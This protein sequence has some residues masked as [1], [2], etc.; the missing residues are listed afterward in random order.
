MFVLIAFYTSLL[1]V[2]NSRS[3]SSSWPVILS[4]SNSSSKSEAVDMMPTTHTS[5]F[6]RATGTSDSVRLK[7][8]EML[9]SALQTGG[10][11]CCTHTHTRARTLSAFERRKLH[12]P[13]EDSRVE[14]TW[15]KS[16]GN[17]AHV[18]WIPF[19][20]RGPNRINLS[21]HA[22]ILAAK[23]TKY[24]FQNKERVML[25]YWSIYISEVELSF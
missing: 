25:M 7:C 8:R 12:Y 15:S 17:H 6:P 11:S 10:E 20:Q 1:G 18:K 22:V 2:L 19:W 13:F 3:L 23:A 14:T 4:S 9:S 24:L 21:S 16:F 5:A